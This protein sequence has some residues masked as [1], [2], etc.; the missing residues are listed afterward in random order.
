MSF[1]HSGNILRFFTTYFR[2]AP[3]TMYYYE[4]AL[5]TAQGGYNNVTSTVGTME[6]GTAT[7][8]FTRPVNST[9]ST[10]VDIASDRHIHFVRGSRNGDVIN[11]HT[12]TWISPM[13]IF[14]NGKANCI[15]FICTLHKSCKLHR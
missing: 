5:D 12:S 3:N 1:D 9:D 13:H 4:P 15:Y 8:H 7:V 6:D 11:K 14:H 2:Y 10:D